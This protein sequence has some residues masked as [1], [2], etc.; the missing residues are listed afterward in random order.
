MECLLCHCDTE[1]F[2]YCN[3]KEYFKCKNCNSVMLNPKFYIS[4]SK[5][6][7]RYAKHDNDVN[8]KGYQ[9]FVSPIVK[10]VL[11][12][13][14][15]NDKGLDFGAGT[16]SAITKLLHDKDYNIKTYDP[17]FY[18]DED[19]LKEKYDY[20]VSCEV[21]EHFHNPD[22]EFDR[23]KAMLKPNGS[24]YL[25]TSIYNEDIDFNSWY[26]KNDE[27]HVFF[28]HKKALE[29]IKRKYRFTEMKIEKDMIIFI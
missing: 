27:T 1:A 15:K 10:S 9:K 3:N 13:Y 11:K 7:E 24:L 21:I 5:E 6:K 22:V 8:D 25:M 28:Y 2:K 17:F 12:D 14:N 29:Y 26:Y 19:R 16:G 20:I 4:S 23:L 18:N